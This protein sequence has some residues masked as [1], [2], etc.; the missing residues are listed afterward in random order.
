MDPTSLPLQGSRQLHQTLDYLAATS[1]RR[2]FATI[3]K[4]SDISDGFRE[5][6]FCD[7]ARCSNVAAR[8]I[9]DQ[10]GS[11]QSFQTLSFIGIPDLRGVAVF[12]GAIKCGYKVLFPSPRNPPST[13]ASLLEQ[14]QCKFVIH[15]TEVNPIVKQLEAETDGVRFVVCPSFQDM[16]EGNP[17]PFVYKQNSWTVAKNNPVVVLHSSG[18]T[19]IPKPITMTHGSFSILDNERNL[20]RV[21]GRKNRDFSIWDF[22]GGGRFYH[23]FPYFHLAGFLSNVVNPIFTEASSPVLGPPLQQ[24]SG[25]LLREIMKSLPLRALYIPPAIA[26]QLL[27]EANSIDLFKKLDFVCYTGAPFSPG[28]GR[29]L[30]EVTELVSLYGSTE[31]FQVPQLVPSKEDWSFMEWNPCFKLEM[32]PSTDEEGAFE[33]VLFADSSTK[34]MSALNHNLPGISEW[35]TKDLFKPHPDKPNLWRYFGRRDDIIVL[36]NGEKFNPI[37]FE[38]ELQ[39]HPLVAGALVVGYGKVYAILLIEAKPTVNEEAL[40]ADS[41][42]PQVAEANKLIP[43]YGRIS[44]SHIIITNRPFERAGKGTI[45]RKLTEKKFE[46]DIAELY[47][48]TKSPSK[49]DNPILAT[50]FTEETVSEFVH[51]AVISAFPTAAAI[52]DTEDLY[53]H[54]FDSLSTTQ[55][56]TT[57]RGGLGAYA[58]SVNLA[59]INPNMIYRFP[60]IRQLA[61]VVGDFLKHEITPSEKRLE[62]RF[63]TMDQ[64]RGRYTCDLPQTPKFAF[65]RPSPG[66]TIA[67]TGSTGSLGSSILASLLKSAN[68]DRVFCLNRGLDAPSRQ[69]KNLAELGVTEMNDARL[70]FMTINLAK[71]HLGLSSKDHA[72]LLEQTDII[73]HNAWRVDFNLSLQSFAEPYLHS[74]RTVV[75]LSAASQKHARICFISSVSSMMGSGSSV[76]E[77]VPEDYSMSMQL[78]YSESKCVAEMILAEANRISSTPIT[79]LRVGQVAGGTNPQAPLW[80]AQ[81]WI[82]PVIKASR[83]LGMIPMSHFPINWVPID[84]ASLV[85]AELVLSP[86]RKTFDVYNIVNP[87]EVS[88]SL[89]AEVLKK[90]FGS[91]NNVIPWEKWAVEARKMTSL[92]E[93]P[94]LEPA[95]KLVDEMVKVPSEISFSTEKAI[96]ASPTMATMKAID[97]NLLCSWLEQWGF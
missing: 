40:S 9:Q 34:S 63:S 64:F 87:Q 18:S 35:R 13:N 29:K 22:S 94:M 5:I 73:I 20:H 90:R 68:V 48:T 45:V 61:K 1:P 28:A 12:F 33:L 58:T 26:E 60:T 85:I 25:N 92:M 76:P 11:S 71:P 49:Q 4:T 95:L 15:A 14:T 54:G 91:N 62:D 88:W 19:G 47:M 43:S 7:M 6:Y 72:L 17:D 77:L 67:L 31:A 89:L 78:G 75:D 97:E 41:I 39:A 80:P 32:Q 70:C 81:E 84:L 50:N 16:L 30:S 55:L 93:D 51:L 56:V 66:I 83:S 65:S 86:S 57:L 52:A 23:I 21:P 36:S 27:Q 44:R 8:W 3:P 74:V 69:K 59:W 46:T 96:A 24:P 79:I 10:F 38:L 2:L 42:W 37:P 53:S 82:Y